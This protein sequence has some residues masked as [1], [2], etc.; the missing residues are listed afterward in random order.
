M[1][2]G[3]DNGQR[4]L[5]SDVMRLFSLDDEVAHEPLGLRPLSKRLVSDSEE[6]VD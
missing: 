4:F 6:R 5:T 3:K 1:V 2:G